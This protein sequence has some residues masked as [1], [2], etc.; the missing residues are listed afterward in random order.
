MHEA[1]PFL[2]KRITKTVSDAL[3]PETILEYLRVLSVLSV[4]VH[5]AAESTLMMKSVPR[6]DPLGLA[7]RDRVNDFIC[8]HNGTG[9]VWYINVESGVHLLIRVT[10]GRVFYHRDLVAEFS[11]KANGR[12]DAGMCYEPDDDEPVNA[13]LLEL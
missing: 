2:T 12:F 10:R 1:K 8:G 7:R 6:T 11:G 5:A 13:V 4:T 3:G 9:V